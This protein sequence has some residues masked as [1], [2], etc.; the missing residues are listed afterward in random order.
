MLRP[1]TLDDFLGLQECHRL[2]HSTSQCL[3]QGAAAC[4]CSCTCSWGNTVRPSCW[5]GVMGPHDTSACARDATRMLFVINDT[6]AEETEC[7]PC[8]VCVVV[9]FL[10]VV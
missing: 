8:N 4:A 5:A 7:L 6:S 2:V 3:Q 9:H 10:L 1:Y